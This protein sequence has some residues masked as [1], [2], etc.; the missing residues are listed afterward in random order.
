MNEC[1]SERVL[2]PVHFV[3]I[4]QNLAN[5]FKLLRDDDML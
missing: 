2:L 4:A 5:S 3:V 1:V